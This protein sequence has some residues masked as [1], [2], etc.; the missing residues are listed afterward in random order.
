VSGR[1]DVLKRLKRT[2]QIV[3]FGRSRHIIGL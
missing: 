3:E 2:N 1:L